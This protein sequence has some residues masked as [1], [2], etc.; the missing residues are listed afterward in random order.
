[1]NGPFCVLNPLYDQNAYIAVLAAGSQQTLFEQNY[2]C[3]G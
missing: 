1:M 2:F 3:S